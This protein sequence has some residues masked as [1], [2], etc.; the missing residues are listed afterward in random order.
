MKKFKRKVL[1]SLSVVLGVL[2]SVVFIGYCIQQQS[3]VI[4]TTI[5]EG[6]G[7]ID[8]DREDRVLVWGYEKCPWCQEAEPI[9]ES[10]AKKYGLDIY[11]VDTQTG[12]SEAEKAMMKEYLQGYEDYFEDGNFHFYVPTVMVI[13]DGKLTDVHCGTVESHDATERDM[14]EEETEEL[15]ERYKSMLTQLVWWS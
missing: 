14:T 6:L 13:K 9:L 12:L 4:P 11:Y 3:E 7:Y 8:D 1:I 15:T 10:V 2:L 5:S